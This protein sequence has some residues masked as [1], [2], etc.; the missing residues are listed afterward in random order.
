MVRFPLMMIDV[1]SDQIGRF[2][3]QSLGNTGDGRQGRVSLAPFDPTDVCP[4]D[5]D[6]V[7]KVLLAPTLFFTEFTYP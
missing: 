5:T 7:R 1:D 3:S 6:F 2:D 4:V